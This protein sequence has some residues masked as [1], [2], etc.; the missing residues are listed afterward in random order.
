MTLTPYEVAS[1]LAYLLTGSLPDDQLLAAADANALATPQQLD[2]QVSRLLQDR[3][4][5]D[6]L[7]AFFTGWLGLDRV[8]T[9]VKDDTVLKLAPTLRDAM[10]GETRAFLLDAFNRDA[11]VGELFSATQTFVNDELAAYYGVTAGAPAPGAGF[12]KTSLGAARKDT[13]LLAQASI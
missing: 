12:V 2:A 5:P 13:G 6:A 10:A 8:R 4:A 1:S 11:P 3:R 7:A 9:I